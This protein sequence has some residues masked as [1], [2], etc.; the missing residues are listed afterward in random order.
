LR[1]QIDYVQTGC[2]VKALVP[3]MQ[4]ADADQ[5][6]ARKLKAELEGDPAA[7]GQKLREIQ[8]AI[9]ELNRKGDE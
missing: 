8:N 6:R 2:A 7:S 5:Q 3:L 9:D 4:R 1:F